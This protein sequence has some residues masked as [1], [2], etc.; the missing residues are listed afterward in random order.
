MCDTQEYTIRQDTH[1]QAEIQLSSRSVK[2]ISG[3]DD[4]V[5]NH[6]AFQLVSTIDSAATITYL[7]LDASS[8]AAFDLVQC[9]SAL[10]TDVSEAD[11]ALT[12]S[13]P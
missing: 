3:S 4:T 8:A 12:A 10:R 9:E 1:Q 11:S 2:Q 13:I 5:D 7:R 6:V